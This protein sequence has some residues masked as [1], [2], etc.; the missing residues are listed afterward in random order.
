MNRHK[1]GC[2][3][4]DFFFAMVL[5][6]TTAECFPQGVFLIATILWPQVFLHIIYLPWSLFARH[7]QFLQDLRAQE[8]ARLGTG[9][10]IGETSGNESCEYR[11]PRRG[12]KRKTTSVGSTSQGNELVVF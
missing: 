2:K 7:L 4:G 11:Q 3:F 10:Q 1:F 12:R 9:T 5:E 6:S 8:F